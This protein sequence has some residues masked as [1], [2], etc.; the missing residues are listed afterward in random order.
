MIPDN[1][2]GSWIVTPQFSPV[3]VEGCSWGVCHFPG[4]LGLLYKQEEQPFE[5]RSESD[6]Y[7]SDKKVQM[8]TAGSLQDSRD[9][10]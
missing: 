7:K 1:P 4:N 10:G 9:M 3:I 2:Q 8:L 5:E 6:Y